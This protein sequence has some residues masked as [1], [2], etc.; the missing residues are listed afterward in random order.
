MGRDDQDRVG[1]LICTLIY[2][3]QGIFQTLEKFQ[4]LQTLIFCSGLHPEKNLG[5]KPEKKSRS[6]GPEIF[7]EFEIVL[8]FSKP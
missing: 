1:L 3:N 8:N 6:A 5:A 2:E 4:A 7:L